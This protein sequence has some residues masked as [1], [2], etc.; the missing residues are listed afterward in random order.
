MRGTRREDPRPVDGQGKD[1]RFRGRFPDGSPDR[2]K[3]GLFDFAQKFQGEMHIGDSRPSDSPG[4]DR[5][6]LV[7][8]SRKSGLLIFSGKSTAM[9]V[10]IGP[11]LSVE[12]A[13]EHVEGFLGGLILD[14]ESVAEKKIVRPAAP[15]G[16]ATAQ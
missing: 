7:E 2:R 13:T 3:P 4:R 16:P 15:S 14:A 11:A 12:K 9:N 1:G 5:F 6:D 8:R 10:L